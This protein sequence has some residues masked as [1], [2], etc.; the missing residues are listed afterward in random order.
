MDEHNRRGAYRAQTPPVALLAVLLAALLGLLASG[1]N[2]QP[3]NEPGA[4][5]TATSK[6]IAV[7]TEPVPTEPPFVP[8]PTHPMMD[9]VW[10]PPEPSKRVE[11]P[12]PT[13]VVD[14]PDAM[15][16]YEIAGMG[17]MY[18]NLKVTADG[19]AVL[20][21]YQGS[22]TTYQLSPSEFDLL[23]QQV[24]AADFPHLA[25]RYWVEDPPGVIAEIPIVTITYIEAGVAKSVELRGSEKTPQPLRD[26]QATLKDLR[27]KVMT[28]GT[29]AARPE[30]LVGYYLEGTG[31]VWLLDVDVEG[32]LYYDSGPA[33]AHMSPEDLAALRATL[34]G[35]SNLGSDEWYTA[36]RDVRDIIYMDEHRAIITTYNQGQQKQW[37]NVLSGAR[38]PQ[39]LEAVL[40]TLAEIYDKYAPGL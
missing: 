25:D 8:D 13:E 3:G 32:G 24:A 20:G 36:P 22:Y 15:L 11:R 7:P 5:A 12:R 35:I 26:V 23:K 19:V 6:S 2:A 28:Q 4:K 10:Q 31:Y 39:K 14:S 9:E 16:V 37:I 29:Q 33:N 27:D 17:G 18:G 40:K 34:D 1:C 38:V 30:L 21:G